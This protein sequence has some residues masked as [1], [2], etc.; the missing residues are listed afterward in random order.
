MEKEGESWGLPFKLIHKLLV[1]KILN[2]RTWENILVC[3]R[4]LSIQDTLPDLKSSTCS[5]GTWA[6]SSRRIEPS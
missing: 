5:E 3:W 1:L 2:L 6:I 4:T